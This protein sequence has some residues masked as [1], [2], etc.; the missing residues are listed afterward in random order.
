MWLKKHDKISGT[1]PEL[2]SESFGNKNPDLISKL[3]PGGISVEYFRELLNIYFGK[4]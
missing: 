2:I 1:I 3:A 4:T